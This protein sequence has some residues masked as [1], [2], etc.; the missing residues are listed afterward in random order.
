MKRVII[1]LIPLLF[2]GS[3]IVNAQQ[4]LRYNYG[5]FAAKIES[6]N[7]SVQTAPAAYSTQPLSS[8]N[9]QT[10][11]GFLSVLASS[12]FVD[13]LA[14]V[15]LYYATNPRDT[16]WVNANGWLTAPLDQWNGIS[17]GPDGRVIEVW[18]ADN[19]LTG[20]LPESLKNLD[21]LKRFY[22]WNNPE[23]SGNLFDFLINYPAL[24]RVSAH[25]CSFTG[26]ILPEV[27]R[28]RLLEI[29]VFNNQLTGEIPVEIGNSPLMDQFNVAG[30]QLTGT[31]PTTI[32]ALR[33]VWDFN[34]SRNQITG[35]IPVEIGQMD[36]LKYLFLED[37]L[38]TGE[39]P[40]EILNCRKLEGFW[41][42]RNNF[43]GTLP[44]VLNLPNFKAIQAG[45][46]INLLVDLPDNLGQLTQLE[47]LS[48]WN[49]KANGG[50]FP[51]GIYNLV[52]LTGLDLSEQAFTGT[53]DA[54]IGNLT[55]LE[56][57]YLRRN[58][59]DGA[60]PVEITV[61]QNLN[62]FDIGFNSFDFLPDISALPNLQNVFLTSNQLQFESLIPYVGRNDFRYS[63]QRNIGTFSNTELAIGA[64]LELSTEIVEFENSNYQWVFNNDSLANSSNFI[65]EVQNFTTSK[66]GRYLLRATHPDLPN[67]ILT[68]AP[69]DLKVAG[70][71]SNWYVD[72]REG[73]IAD[74]RKLDQAVFATK[75]G[76]TIYVAGSPTSYGFVQ[77][78]SART[79]IGPGYFLNENAETQFNKHSATLDGLQIVSNIRLQNGSLNASNTKLFGLEIGQLTFQNILSLVDTLENVLVDGVKTNSVFLAG[80]TKNLEMRN[81]VIGDFTI[82]AESFS[83][84]QI[85]SYRQNNSF[86]RNIIRRFTTF[87]SSTGFSLALTNAQNVDWNYNVIDTVP[88]LIENFNFK[89]SLIRV[90]NSPNSSLTNSTVVDYSNLLTNRSGT[91]SVDNDYLP[92]DPTLDKGVFA[93]SNPYRLS[94][95]PPVPSIYSIEIGPRLSAKLR[96]KSNNGSNIS[97]IR[98]V[99]NRNNQSS[100][101]FNVSG[102]NA[103]NRIEVEFLPN[104]S[105]IQP[106]QMYDLVFQAVDQS[107][108][109]SHRTYIPYETLAASLSGTVVDIDNNNVN[110]GNIRLFAINPFANKY[111]TVAVQPLA[112]TNTFSFENLILGD[113]IILADPDTIEYPDLIPT[114]LGNTLDWQLADTLFL[115]G[116]V[117]GITIQVE[118]EPA[119][120]TEKGS[121]IQGFL[122]EQYEDADSSLRVLPRAR[123][124]GAGVSVRR[125]TGSSRPENSSLRLLD[126]HYELV[127]YMKTNE[128]GEFSFSN[129]PEGDY[130]IRI[131]YPGVETDETSDID[132]NLTGQQGEIL[133]FEALVEDGSISLTRYIINVANTNSKSLTFSFYPNPVQNEL[134]LN[135]ENALD[136]NELII[137]DLK[138][139]IHKKFKLENGQTKI[140]LFN[141]PTGSYILRLQDD[142]GKYLISKMIKQ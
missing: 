130:R 69:I 137:F 39:V 49:T 54:R 122:E 139:T 7:A 42:I 123:L 17:L 14:L 12:N 26:T 27:F 52:N 126:N 103:S 41:F 38:L 76:D 138:G 1:F 24:E 109:R 21:S 30:N 84:T 81:S 73:T 87:G 5:N 4:Q 78:P 85:S 83:P 59:L 97:T 68:S 116:A 124:S 132:F 89:N 57:L 141:L 71:K 9:S 46:N 133:G 105:A 113:Y 72:N 22:F 6:A 11:L 70:G 31:I 77:L 128:N 18:L 13:S 98:Y 106:N 142:K 96:V 16:A 63:P 82:L 129:L 115:Q 90:N 48:I 118:K 88:A 60:F 110:E 47:Y 15:D 120:L 102:F 114:Y 86:N 44:D 29:R 107:G 104:R 33:N 40:T 32:G 93:G 23:L 55:K 134:H 28:P 51:E 112:G 20:T 65:L 80:S 35:S 45:G 66:A 56:S 3:E 36:S 135:M 119:P 50:A 125:L 58:Q 95:L 67:F 121:I 2:L 94:G 53:I 79:L 74:F 34:L 136:A 108:K 25:D 8:G 62:T 100:S 19:N 92:L 117:S 99:Y 131:E 140:E 101:R 127:A 43:S 37:M 111:D 64:T 75:V 61:A 10:Q 91:F